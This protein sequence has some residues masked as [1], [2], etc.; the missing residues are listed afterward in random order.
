[1][2]NLL[3]LIF[4]SHILGDFF[5]Q[6]TAWV[7][8]K[9]LRKWAS[10]HLYIHVLIHFI[11]LICITGIV[12]LVEEDSTGG[13]GYFLLPALLITATHLLI[14]GIKL[15]LQ[16][17]KTRRSW[18]FIDQVLHIIVLI[19]AAVIV[20]GFEFFPDKRILHGIITVLAAGLFLMKPTS[21]F[22]RTII[23]RWPPDL[24]GTSETGMTRTV[25]ISDQRSLENAGELIGILERLIILTF[26]LLG[27]WE[28]VGFLLAAKSVFRFG[29]LKEARDMKLTEYVLIGTLLS[30]GTAIL[31][32]VLASW[33]IRII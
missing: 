32:G 6:K 20:K 14:D 25:R 23:S 12:N 30:F 17:E 19:A 11:L 7:K 2:I 8:D 21:F 33:I 27:R 28:G 18:F 4:I 3:V 10:P 5:L 22:I 26:I 29:D 16:T 24:S 31:T 1:M 9:E 13:F 15:S